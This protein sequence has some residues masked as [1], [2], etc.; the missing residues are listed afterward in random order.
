MLIK[1]TRPEDSHWNCGLG[2][3]CGM[4]VVKRVPWEDSCTIIDQKEKFFLLHTEL[5]C[6]NT[7][8]PGKV[9]E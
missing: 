3:E 4:K 1:E 2:S 7:M 5:Q 8:G 9:N 6:E